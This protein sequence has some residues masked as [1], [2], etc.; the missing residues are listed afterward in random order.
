[1]TFDQ[2]F[3]QHVHL[4][5]K[6]DESQ[7]RRACDG[8]AV[9]FKLSQWSTGR[10]DDIQ[11]WLDRSKLTTDEQPLTQPQVKSVQCARYFSH[12]TQQNEIVNNAIKN[13]HNTK[14][15]SLT[16]HSQKPNT[17]K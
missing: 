12:F 3:P 7:I 17:V 14:H 16:T 9:Q 1:M 4:M 10:K 2:N 13:L 8:A 5:L 15:A 6:I 11:N